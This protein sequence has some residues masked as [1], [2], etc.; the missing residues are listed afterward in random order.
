[1]RGFAGLF[2]FIR[3]FHAH[4]IGG[5]DAS[6]FRKINGISGALFEVLAQL[7]RSRDHRQRFT[8]D[9]QTKCRAEARQ[10]A[11][12]AGLS[13]S[14]CADVRPSASLHPVK[15]SGFALPS[16][17]PVFTF[18]R[19]AETRSRPPCSSVNPEASVIGTSKAGATETGRARPGS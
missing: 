12:A 11:T 14:R 7:L 8:G 18:D 2:L 4:R 9:A 1:M 15:L 3:L 17:N 10:K 19:S 5:L 16:A 6:P 13:P